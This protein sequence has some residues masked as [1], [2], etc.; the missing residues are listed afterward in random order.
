MGQKELTTVLGA[1]TQDSQNLYVEISGISLKRCGA[2]LPRNQEVYD[3]TECI[4][5]HDPALKTPC[6]LQ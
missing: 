4:R 5:V 6:L 1:N 3:R 2:K